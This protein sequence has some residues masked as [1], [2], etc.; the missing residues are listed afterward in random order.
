MYEEKSV[1]EKAR[2]GVTPR[3]LHA[4]NSCSVL[5][6]EIKTKKIKSI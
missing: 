6:L 5:A 4:W 1:Q 3:V 2:R